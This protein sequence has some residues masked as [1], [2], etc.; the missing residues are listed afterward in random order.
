MPAT[1]PMAIPAIAA[2]LRDFSDSFSEFAGLSGEALPL[3][4]L[5]L[6]LSVKFVA[7]NTALSCVELKEGLRLLV[8]M[9][10]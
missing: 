4:V 9:L 1:A 10:V 2:V 5:I 6:A 8:E 7:S 3:V